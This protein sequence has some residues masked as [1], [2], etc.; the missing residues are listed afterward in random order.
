MFSIPNIPIVALT[1]NAFKGDRERCLNAGM[2]DYLAKPVDILDL[3]KTLKKWIPLL[4]PPR[5]SNR[6]GFQT[7]HLFLKKHPR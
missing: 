3:I 5:Q 7:K 2:N 4:A 1:A 6:K